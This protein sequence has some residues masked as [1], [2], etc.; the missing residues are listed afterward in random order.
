MIFYPGDTVRICGEAA[1]FDEA[2]L[3]YLAHLAGREGRVGSVQTFV[4]REG[5]D[6]AD[7][8]FHDETF[9]VDRSSTLPASFFTLVSRA[10]PSVEGG[11]PFP[12]DV[13]E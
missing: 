5:A 11:E 13:I 10:K 4:R 1:R 8:A 6:F 7:V 12:G 9:K 3:S 2:G